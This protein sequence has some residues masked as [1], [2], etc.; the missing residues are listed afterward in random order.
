MSRV[1]ETSLDIYTV[2]NTGERTIDT[3]ACVRFVLESRTGW[4]RTIYSRLPW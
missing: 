1:Q 2:F 4:I 3:S